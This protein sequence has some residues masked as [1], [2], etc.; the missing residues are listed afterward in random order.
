M[1]KGWLSLVRTVLGS[2]RACQATLTCSRGLKKPRTG[3]SSFQKV[4]PLSLAFV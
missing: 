1:R 3:S 4:Q 2:C